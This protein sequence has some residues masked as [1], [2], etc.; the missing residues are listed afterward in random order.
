VETTQP[1][2]YVLRRAIAAT[3]DQVIVVGCIAL[4]WI[5]QPFAKP[6]ETGNYGC[7]GCLLFLASIGVYLVYFGFSEAHFGQSPGKGACD[8]RVINA[9]GG[10][11]SFGACVTRHVLDVV[12]FQMFGLPALLTAHFS[13]TRQRLG[14]MI[15]K[16]KVVRESAPGSAG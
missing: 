3:I 15:A 10:K 14:D 9:A 5:W 16:T 7:D 2:A 12:E 4:F 6:D 13:P 11:A 8:L 1:S